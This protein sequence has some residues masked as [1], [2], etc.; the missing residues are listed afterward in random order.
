MFG[1]LREFNLLMVCELS[2]VFQPSM[3]EECV[4]RKWVK[5]AGKKLWL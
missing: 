2:Q 1:A 4:Q 5:S 3:L